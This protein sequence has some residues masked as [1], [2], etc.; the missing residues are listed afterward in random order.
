[1]IWGVN[2]KNHSFKLTGKNVKYIFGPVATLIITD[3]QWVHQQ[4][5]F[6]NYTRSVIFYLRYKPSVS[7]SSN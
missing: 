4:G 3:N 5:F 2:N 1:M 7:I 6:K